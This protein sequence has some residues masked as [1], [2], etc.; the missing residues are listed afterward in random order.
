MTA[1]ITTSITK[2][3]GDLTNV[4]WT[5]SCL[6]M[7][8]SASEFRQRSISMGFGLA[9]DIEQVVLPRMI[10]HLRD[11]PH[12]WICLFDDTVEDGRKWS[13]KLGDLIAVSELDVFVRKINGQMDK[14]EKIAVA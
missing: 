7:W 3:L 10:N 11:L 1:I 14:N 4:D 2:S 9:S 13:K 8:A 5:A 12:S 6:Q